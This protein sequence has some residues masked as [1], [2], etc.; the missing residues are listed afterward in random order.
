MNRSSFGGGLS[1]VVSSSP[2]DAIFSPAPSHP[3]PPFFLV[4]SLQPEVV[5][6]QTN[7]AAN[8]QSEVEMGQLNRELAL[9][10]F[11]DVITLVTLVPVLLEEFLK[12]AFT[13]L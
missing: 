1:W 10:S 12:N 11:L 8:F 3:V 5:M 9:G 2:R 7:N 4:P 13:P 6:G